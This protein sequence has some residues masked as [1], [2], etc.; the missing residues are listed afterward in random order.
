LDLAKVPHG[1]ELVAGFNEPER[2]INV[3]GHAGL[4]HKPVERVPWLGIN[5]D[6]DLRRLVVAAPSTAARVA[7]VFHRLAFIAHVGG[8]VHFR[9]GSFSFRVWLIRAATARLA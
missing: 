4:Q 9:H 7:V 8:F 1:L 6:T 3:R 5:K 2:G